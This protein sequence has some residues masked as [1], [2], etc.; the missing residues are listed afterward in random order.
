MQHKKSL[1]MDPDYVLIGGGACIKTYGRPTMTGSG[2][3]LK[4]NASLNDE[5]PLRSYHV[6]TKN[7]ETKL[8]DNGG[9]LK[10]H[11]LSVYAI[12]IRARNHAPLEPV[13]TSRVFKDGRNIADQCHLEGDLI[14]DRGQNNSPMIGGGVWVTGDMNFLSWSMPELEPGGLGK[15]KAYSADRAG[16]TN[17]GE[18]HV[19][20]IGLKNVKA[21]IEGKAELPS[22]TVQGFDDAFMKWNA[23]GRN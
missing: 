9:Q 18:M 12:G 3:P 23:E 11:A 10:S 6:K 14:H 1:E 7:M 8:C 16:Y 21:M 4:E 15:W 20:T 19:V 17:Q 13:Y 2:F 22:E 5:A